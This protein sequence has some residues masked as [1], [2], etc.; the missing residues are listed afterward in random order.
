MDCTLLSITRKCVH[1]RAFLFFCWKY[2][3]S[4]ST[5][6]FVCKTRDTCGRS[7]P[8]VPSGD[9]SYHRGLRLPLKRSYHQ[10]SRSGDPSYAPGVRL[11]ILRY[12]STRHLTFG[13]N[14]FQWPTYRTENK[15][16]VFNVNFFTLW[17]FTRCGLKGTLSLFALAL[18]A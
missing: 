1:Y 3:C 12:T 16:I 5:H 6:S 14:S 10:R 18:F 8:R 4:S 7:Q 2:I 11:S 9:P 17:L 13:S 15:E